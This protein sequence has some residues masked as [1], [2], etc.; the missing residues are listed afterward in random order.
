MSSLFYFH[1]NKQ[2]A[3]VENP[4]F[5]NWTFTLQDID[6]AVLAQIDRN[7][8]GFGFEVAHCPLIFTL[9]PN[10]YFI[11]S[12]SVSFFVSSSRCLM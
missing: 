2:F 10:L 7:W 4:G 9:Q 6:G 12:V 11:V 3:A 8:R 5:W 1:R